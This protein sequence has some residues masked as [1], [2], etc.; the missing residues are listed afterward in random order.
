MLGGGGLAWQNAWVRSSGTSIELSASDLSQ[1]LGCRHRT[2]L[3]LAVACGLREAPSWVDP[4][5][6]VLQQ[7]GLDHERSYADALRAEGLAVSDISGQTGDDAIARSRD[8]MRA[9]VD[10]ILQSALCDGRW[11][12]RPDVLRRIETQSAL[13]A[14]SYQAVDTKLAKETRGGTVLQLALYSEMLSHVQGV[15]PEFFHVVTPDP[16]TPVHTFRVHDFAAYFRLIRGRL[17]AMSLEAPDAI[18]AANYPEPVEHCDICRWWSVCNK[19]RRDDDHL[20]FVAGVSRL[21]SRELQAAGVMTLA[22]LGT[23]PL[24]LPFTPRRGAIETYVRVREQARL[25]LAGRTQ[26]SPVHEL[27]PIEDNQG[28]ARLPTPAAGDIFLDIEGDPFAR[29]N[30]REYLFGL[31]VL[32]A[33]R[34]ST[35]RSYWACSDSEERAAFETVVDEILQSWASNPGMHVYHYAPYEPAALRR[36]MGR[37]ATREAEVD[38][39]LRAELFVDLHAVVKHGLR[40]SVE[41][42][43]IK[44]LEPFYGFKRTVELA[45]ARTSLRVVERALELGA[46][47]AITSEVR[48][49][50]ESYNRDDCLSALQLRGWLEELRA[51]VEAGGTLVPRPEPKD[52]AAPEKL[53][54]RGRRVQALV[55]ALTAD[56]PV[57]RAERNDDQQARWLLAHL[58]DWHRREAKAPWWEFFRLRDLSE[59]ELFDEKAAVSGLR[60]VARVGGT[61]R[62]PIDRYVYPLQD[63]DVRDGDSL[64]LPD[65]TDFGSVEAIDR[66]GRTID[67]K[68][69]GA[70]ADVHPTA[71]F[72]HSIV[73]SDVLADA[74]LRIADDVVRHGAS[75][76]AQFKAARELLLGRPPRLRSGAFEVDAEETAFEFAVRIASELDDTVLAIQG[77][78]GAGKTY[79]GAQ[80]I[81]EL[82]RRG[83]SVGVTAVS[84]KVIRNLLDAVMRVA[85]EAGLQVTCVHKVTTKSSAPSTIEEVT[86]NGEVIARLRD[87]R[88]H[89]VGGTPW[90]WAR[91]ESQGAVE[92]LFVDEAGQMSLAN[93]LA[94]SPAA[95]SVVLLGD[96]QQLEQPQ[97]G[98]HPEGADVSA[99]EHVLGGH[100]TIPSD[101]GIFLPETWRLAPSICTFTSEVFYEGRLHARAGLERQVLMGTGPFEGAGLWVVAVG[102]DG[103]QNS[104]PEEVDTVDRIVAQLLHEDARWIDGKGATRPMTLNDILVVAPYNAQVGLLGERLAPRGVR[105]GTVDRF[106]GQEAPVVIYSMATSTPEDAPRGMEFL[107]SLNRLNVAT[108]RARCACILI[109]NPRLFE[110]ECKSPRQMQLANALCRYVELAR[111]VSVT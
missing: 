80:M 33:D 100:Q 111:A 5:L 92:V 23:L 103:N 8:A 106:Q 110:P 56:V 44:D 36:L 96:P 66:V 39:M 78:P 35:S 70:Q 48:A 104:S 84:H 75:G 53:D 38:R 43:S 86:D 1:F 11:F 21:Q 52:G 3:D 34:S 9:G 16:K 62:S 46:T 67:V 18:A 58:V 95:K 109:A 83:A 97:Q 90:L 99:M 22:Q 30:G 28:L 17:E 4:V 12:G 85:S 105:V 14:W 49:A 68:K 77:P 29:D 61:K 20:S 87:A 57:D 81:C 59:E 47:D 93:V 91:A 79:T 27:L 94:E 32:R 64:Y 50:V 26:R 42:Y 13:G 82:V 98:S 102:H 89:V 63:T 55:A 74:L 6:V 2:A 31:V 108:S 25:Q 60:F 88:A 15:L 51:S 73:N 107:Y 65:G 101:R 76:G 24:P 41:R 10:V 45:D 54:E 71:V 72:A 40:A 37:H 69:R 19:R 7:R